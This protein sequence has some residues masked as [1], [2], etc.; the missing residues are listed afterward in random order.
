MQIID[1]RKVN[2]QDCHRCLRACPVNA[3]GLLNGHAKV[4][5]E[6]CI[7]CGK[8]VAECPQYAKRVVSQLPEIKQAIAGG[9]KVVL[10]LASTYLGWFD[11]YEPKRLIGILKRI[12]FSEVA[13]TAVGSEAIAILYRRLF[14]DAERTLIAS[15]CPVV[16]N[17]IKKYYPQLTQYLAPV[18]SPM[19]AH[20]LMLRQQFGKDAF[21]VF[22]GPCIGKFEDERPKSSVDAVLTFAQ[23]RQWLR[24]EAKA[25]AA[26]AL[27]EAE[28]EAAVIGRIF[29]LAGG[30]L[31]ALKNLDRLSTDVISVDGIEHCIEVFESLSSGAIAPKFIEA[32]SCEGG[33][34]GGPA[35]GGRQPL[36]LRRLRMLE[37]A[38]VLPDKPLLGL[39][40]GIDFSCRQQSAP[41]RVDVPNEDE[42]RVI[43]RKTGKF[44]RA[45]EKN[46]G[47]CGYGSCREKAVAVWQGV[48]EITICMPYMRSK[49][50][51]FAS[52]IVENV[53]YG[54]V[55]V[56]QK[57]YMQ[58]FNPAM[59][60][61][62]GRSN[63]MLK[64]MNLGAFIDCT[65]FAEALR[66]DQKIIGR[67]VDYPEY[68][69]MTEQMILP[70]L[71]NSLVIAIIADITA[72]EKL[73]QEWKKTKEETVAKASEIINQ[74]MKVAQEIAGLLG[75]TTADTKAALLEM[76][77]VLQKR[78]DG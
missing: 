61:M 21:V 67:R 20:G 40:E 65:S 32:F 2:C 24:E 72:S 30:V 35:G 62:F 9:R 41:V 34:I 56:D 17:L 16:V 39:P 10:S 46:C 76:M 48:A 69:I 71:K 33:C 59:E 78:E 49:A 28:P 38:K 75:E 51:S 52:V 44:S 23:L 74:Q 4:L 55:A 70:V 73:A 42:I 15:N 58:E 31:K 25:D 27:P 14:A 36:S 53:P 43:L 13:E 8:C 68:G 29:P 3:I 77:Q 54:I 19:A 45:D 18:V 26:E 64:G 50:E 6:R 37:Y 11:A 22:A 63:P 60:R 66:S 12:G 5:D 1:T 47:A 57:M 7:L